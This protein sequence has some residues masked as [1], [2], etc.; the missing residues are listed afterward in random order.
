MVSADDPTMDLDAD[1]ELIVARFADVLADESTWMEVPATLGA[2]V[3]RAIASERR[4][5]VGDGPFDQ[6]PKPPPLPVTAQP[7]QSPRPARRLAP[8]IAAAAAAVAAL[9]LGTVIGR[10][11]GGS[12]SDRQVAVSATDLAPDID[13]TVGVRTVRSGVELRIDA[14]G[15]PRRDGGDFYEGWLKSCDGAQLV[16]IGT[17][18]ELADVTAWAGVSTDDFPILTV[19]REAVAAPQDV[20]QGSSGEVVLTAQVGPDCPS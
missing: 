16:P 15:L 5:L 11:T 14:P 13:G 3:S 18:H 2:V 1:D 12:D 10:S 17:F 7:A 20:A 19:T 4:Q 8:V 9:A 6:T